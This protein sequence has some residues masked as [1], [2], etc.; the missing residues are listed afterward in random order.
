MLQQTV[1]AN[2][3]MAIM[4]QLGGFLLGT[5]LPRM[6]V[7]DLQSACAKPAHPPAVPSQGNL[8][9]PAELPSVCPVPVLHH[10]RMGAEV[11]S[12]CA[13]VMAG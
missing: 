5:E 1:A 2:W 11:S 9:V 8:E 3:K 12:G 10:L 7:S 4:S 6:V 13:E